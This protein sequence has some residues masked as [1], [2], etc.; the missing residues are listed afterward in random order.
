VLLAVVEAHF[1]NRER[2]L[3]LTPAAIAALNLFCWWK[4]R[5]GRAL[6]KE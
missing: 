2:A 5:A 4:L 3:F 6:R 1:L